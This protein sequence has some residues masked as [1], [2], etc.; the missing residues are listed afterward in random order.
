[1]I[2]KKLKLNNFRCFGATETVI[3]FDKLTAFI[4][5]NSTGKTAALQALVKLFGTTQAEREIRRADFHISNPENPDEISGKIFYI[6]AVFCF[7][8]LTVE[9]AST[10][11]I[12]SFFKY[13]VIDEPGQSP[14]L[15]VRLEAKFIQDD[16]IEGTIDFGYYF[17]K[18]SENDETISESSRIRAER[19]LLSNIKCLYIPA[20]RNPSDQLKS[21][22]GTILYRLFKSIEWLPEKKE[23]L[24]VLIEQV[25]TTLNNVPD[26]VALQAVLQKQWNGYHKDTRY[27]NA[28]IEFTSTDFNSV[29]KAAGIKFAP[30]EIPRDY[31]VSELGDGLRSLF[32]FTLVNTLLEV[33]KVALRNIE[34]GNIT[35]H[36]LKTLPPILTILAVEE[37]E[38]HIAPQLLGRVILHIKETA[39]ATNAQVVLTSH[40]PAIVKRIDATSIRFFRLDTTS[41]SSIVS[42]ITLPAEKDE[43]FKYVKEAIEAYPE[44]YF[45][46]LVIL[47][48]GDS[49]MVV[50][51]RIMDRLHKNIDVLGIAIAPLGGR[52]VNHFWRLLTQ[53][54]IPYITLL[55]LDNERYGGGWGRIKYVI[56][57]L[58][59]NG[60]ERD[61]LL[62]LSDGTILSYI[63]LEQMHLR[64]ACNVS[65]MLSWLELLQRY[66]VYF[67]A[68]LDLDFLLLECYPDCY[69]NTVDTG[70]G[71]FIPKLGPISLVESMS[72]PP[73]DYIDRA[74]KN[75]KDVLKEEGGDGSTYR[76]EDKHLMIWYKYLFLDRSKPG[77]HIKAL[78]SCDF[79]DMETLPEPIK[80]IISRA[81]DIL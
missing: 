76:E 60:A 13:F 45:A 17:I 15:R 5:A 26:V 21:V 77:T 23:E 50:L 12:P 53:L 11:A 74:N 54:N 55:D 1:M 27:A 8:E 67:S 9:N 61:S 38:N 6:E 2:L 30:T 41:E 64:S 4:G 34:A 19:S 22:S 14:Y 37:P 42:T 73:Q 56:K 35:P 48:E 28:K 68:P 63:Q 20:L 43:A 51:P 81:I 80:T 3:G 36:N 79:S 24:Q 40:T 69:K 72:P 16:S 65:D 31:D 52:H 46:R 75:T 10:T 58:I 59:E 62:K 71:P 39:A 47:G 66:N 78:A 57:Q 33:E 29:I 44:I 18:S 49:E 7:P 25:N 32:Y 70:F